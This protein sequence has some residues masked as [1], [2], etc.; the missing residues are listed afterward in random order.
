MKKILI[1]LFLMTG[2][3]ACEQQLD[4]APNS[5]PEQALPATD[6]IAGNLVTKTAPGIFPAEGI[7]ANASGPAAMGKNISQSLPGP[8]AV[9]AITFIPNAGAIWRDPATGLTHLYALQLPGIP[10]SRIV[11]KASLG[12]GWEGSEFMTMDRENF[13][14]VWGDAVYKAPKSAPDSWSLI[15]PNNGEDLK[16]IVGFQSN[17]T[18]SIGFYLIRGN[19]MTAVN[20]SGN[21]T[22][23]FGCNEAFAGNKRMAYFKSTSNGGANFL[24]RQFSDKTWYLS[25]PEGVITW[26]NLSNLS[27]TGMFEMVGN[28]VT[29]RFY[30]SK[31]IGNM[32]IDE[33]NPGGEGSEPH[34]CGIDYAPSTSSLVVNNGYLWIMSN[35]LHQVMTLGSQKGKSAYSEPGMNGIQMACADPT[36]VIY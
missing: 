22:T 25:N 18:P 21:F 27:P 15:V 8:N 33:I 10:G 31:E 20:A 6:N 11:K 24:F 12:T 4:P 28:P 14:V 36:L 16:G 3:I 23:F 1:A 2:L 26:N 17:S 34:F 7:R 32:R 5:N 9:A 35:T 29:N 19:C 30:K 13:Y